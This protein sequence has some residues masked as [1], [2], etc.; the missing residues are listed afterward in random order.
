MKS[1][2]SVQTQAAD[3]IVGLLREHAERK[4]VDPSAPLD[5]RLDRLSRGRMTDGRLLRS[6]FVAEIEDPHDDS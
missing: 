2:M 1:R 6:E 5:T 4:E 3:L